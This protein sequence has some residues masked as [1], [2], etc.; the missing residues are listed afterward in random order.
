MAQIYKIYMNESALIFADFSPAPNK[1]LQAIDHQEIDLEKLYKA[2]KN[3]KKTVDYWVLTADPK[4]SF[5]KL[6]SKFTTI[7]A[8]GGLVK[9]GEGDYLLIFRLGKWDLPKGKLDEGEK[10]KD[11]AV[12]EVEEE[13][14]IKVNYLGPKIQKS[15][16]A[17]TLRGELVLKATH[18]FEM[19]V[20]KVPKLKP[21]QAEDITD[22]VWLPKDRFAKIRKNTYRLI[23]DILDTVS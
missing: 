5:K 1:G 8:G 14:G 17:Y 18:W 22:A 2:T 16:H 6:A 3:S 9:N 4:A 21:Q 11:A 12:R 15:Y 13:C 19:G 7:V 20:N 23:E 10:I